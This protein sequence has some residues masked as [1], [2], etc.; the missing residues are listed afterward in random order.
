LIAAVP[1][2]QLADS[3]PL[4]EWRWGTGRV[5]YCAAVG[6]ATAVAG[7]RLGWSLVLPP[8]WVTVVAGAALA[9]VDVRV[10]RLPFRLTATIAATACLALLVGAASTGRYRP[11]G[12]AAVCGLTAG[13]VLLAVALATGGQLGLGDVALAAALATYL[14]GAGFVPA[15]MGVGCGFL[16]AAGA[17]AA[18]AR[19]AAAEPRRRRRLPLG[20][21]LLG[22]WYATAVLHSP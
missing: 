16:I 15:L 2:S 20:P 19:H 11:V 9:V 3:A 1:V 12:I 22:G 14:G 13:A 21:A 4:G 10:Q 7:H 5:G 17:L 6:A 8:A 18:P